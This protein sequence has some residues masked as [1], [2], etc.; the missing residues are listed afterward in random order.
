MSFAR[1]NSASVLAAL[2]I[3]I[4]CLAVAGCGGKSEASGT[5]TTTN[6]STPS[7]ASSSTSSTATT[8]VPPAEQPFVAEADAICRKANMQLAKTQLKKNTT[9]AAAAGVAARNAATERGALAELTKLTPPSALAP[10][11]AKMLSVRRSLVRGLDELAAA[12]RR[13]G[14]KFPALRKQKKQ[15]HA[16]LTA[17]GSKAGFKD[18]AKIG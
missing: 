14:E 17:V 6:A 5:G 16:E 7:T 9:L 3:A 2:C 13:G 8:A 1:R 18:C 4:A 11:W 15:L 10:T 12:I